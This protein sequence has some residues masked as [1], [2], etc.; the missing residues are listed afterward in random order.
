MRKLRL[1]P[2]QG[3]LLRLLSEAG[4]ENLECIRATLGIRNDAE[5][6]AQEVAS[7]RCAGFVA[8]SVERSTGLPSLV[9]TRLGREVLIR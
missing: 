7:L 3:E 6:F 1:S 9:L 8:D 4:E 2:I 5:E